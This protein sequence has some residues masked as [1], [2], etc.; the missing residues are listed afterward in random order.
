M[1]KHRLNGEDP[2]AYVLSAN[3]HRR[4][5][6]KG[7][8]AMA[9]A[10]IYPD[11]TAGGRGN[12]NRPELDG[13]NRQRVAEAHGDRAQMCAPARLELGGFLAGIL[14]GAVAAKCGFE[15]ARATAHLS[16]ILVARVDLAAQNCR[17]HALP[18]LV[19]VERHGPSPDGGVSLMPRQMVF[20]SRAST[21]EEDEPDMS[22][23]ALDAETKRLRNLIPA[24]LADEVGAR[25][26][27]IA[28]VDEQLEAIKLE[29]VRRKITAAQG[30][31]FDI[32]LSPPGERTAIDKAEL[33][34]V[35]GE[36]F[37][38]KFSK[39][40]PGENWTLRCNARKQRGV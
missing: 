9:V 34:E 15:R 33:I 31:L 26:A 37:V 12:K 8:R 23:P 32:A 35:F 6:T 7:Q 38:A 3:I 40:T 11:R 16:L 21:Y 4:H 1:T 22:R 19:L 2:T 28:D 30:E 10:M 29:C 36:R 39:T 17:S 20:P 27:M 5:M 25:K 14:I 24:Q 18:G 13:F